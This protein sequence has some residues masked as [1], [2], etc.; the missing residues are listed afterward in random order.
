MMTRDFLYLLQEA[1][2][3]RLT[4]GDSVRRAGWIPQRLLPQKTRNS[5]EEL[6]RD[7]AWICGR[8]G[9]GGP[10]EIPTRPIL[11]NLT[12]PCE[13]RRNIPSEVQGRKPMAQP[14]GYDMEDRLDLLK[15]IL[16]HASFDHDTMLEIF[17][18]Y[19]HARRKILDP[20]DELSHADEII[21]LSDVLRRPD[22][23]PYVVDIMSG[24]HII[25]MDKGECY[26]TWKQLDSVDDRRSSHKSDDTQYQ[27]EGPLCHGILFSKFGGYTWLQLEN[28]A[29]HWYASLN[30]GIDYAV[31]KKTGLNQG[32]YGMSKFNDKNPLRLAQWCPYGPPG[33][34]N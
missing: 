29:W 15:D 24:A 19:F 11:E 25:I 22:A 16:R 1:A 10:A 17:H 13:P 7:F 3:A 34:C 5:A 4:A 27:V 26:R 28:T 33:L 21:I 14:P 31:Y 30:H 12:A 9:P 2:A 8:R 32:P 6:A 23:R 18:N 20:N